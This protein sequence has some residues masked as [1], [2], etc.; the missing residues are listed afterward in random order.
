MLIFTVHTQAQERQW[1]IRG[2]GDKTC[3][4]FIQVIRKGDIFEQN[5]FLQYLQ[6]FIN[7]VEVQRMWSKQSDVQNATG[8]TV[9]L[10]TESICLQKPQNNMYLT[11]AEIVSKLVKK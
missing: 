4:E 11:A 6:G 10:M 3:A 9:L 5:V 1:Y 2:D 8:A 7:G